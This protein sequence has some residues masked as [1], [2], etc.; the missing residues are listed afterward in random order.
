MD[1]SAFS[2]ALAAATLVGVGVFLFQE[3]GT[4]ELPDAGAPTA[5]QPP[6]LT[7]S[8]KA[9]GEL[10]GSL[11]SVLASQRRTVT[12]ARIENDEASVP[13]QCYT[14]TEGRHNPCYTCHQTYDASGGDR[15]NG[16]QD[17]ALQ[18][19]YSFSDVGVTNHYQ[20]LWVDRK[21]WIES[22]SDETILAYVN[23]ENYSTLSQ[24]LVAERFDGFVPDLK[25]YQLGALAFDQAG[26]AKDGSNC[27]AFN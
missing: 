14:K 6:D 8:A 2:S 12:N 20:N 9:S 4:G 23:S 18:G 27:V 24:R 5:V 13:S 1:R 3:Q 19:E 7:A 11:P 22:I 10:P 25:D 17:G 21:A 15:L 26:L 16:V